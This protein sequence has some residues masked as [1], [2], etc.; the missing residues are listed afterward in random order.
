MSCETLSELFIDSKM[1]G[2]MGAIWISISLYFM[3]T[4]YTFVPRRRWVH[5]ASRC[6]AGLWDSRRRGCGHL[7][8]GPNGSSVSRGERAELHRTRHG[9]R[10]LLGTLQDLPTPP[11]PLL[12]PGREVPLQPPVFPAG[13]AACPEMTISTSNNHKYA[14]I[15]TLCTE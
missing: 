13:I 9:V 7:R 4:T 10:R 15:D 3:K 2:I 11:H 14:A 12:Q 5:A 1:Q 6:P 8:Q